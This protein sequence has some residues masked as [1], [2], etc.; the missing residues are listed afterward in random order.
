MASVSLIRAPHPQLLTFLCEI[1]P[2]ALIQ[3][4][5]P[6]AFTSAGISVLPE[7][8]QAVV[9][10]RFVCNV[11]PLKL[12]WQLEKR[13]GFWL[14][15]PSP[16]LKQNSD[17]YSVSGK[18]W[19]NQSFGERPQVPPVPGSPVD[20]HTNGNHG[21]SVNEHTSHHSRH[22]CLN[23]TRLPAGEGGFAHLWLCLK[24]QVG[25]VLSGTESRQ[26]HLHVSGPNW[27]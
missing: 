12:W 7:P 22:L 19:W 25:L 27:K 3:L 15:S 11:L 24:L 16:C 17:C 20:L 26:E 23:S 14:R 13:W 6:A 18:D 2:F 9:C 1:F 21:P 5:S 4:H 8:L 10:A